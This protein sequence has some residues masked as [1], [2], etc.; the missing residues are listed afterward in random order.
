ME[1]ARH[2]WK[3]CVFYQ[4]YPRSFQDSNGDGMGDLRG[5][6]DRIDYLVELGIGA[7][8]LGPVCK[9]PND[10]MGY[11]I[12]DY[13]DIMEQFGTMADWEE[14][15]DKLHENG[16]RIMVDLVVNHTSDEHPWF[17]AARRAKDDPRH[18]YY[19]WRPGRDGRE[20]NN[21]AS[22]FT[23]SAWEYNEATD[24]YY[25]HLFSKK[26]PDLNW[27]NP[28][29]RREVYDMMTWW[30]DKGADGF[31]MDVINLLCKTPGR[32]PPGRRT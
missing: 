18:D 30:L 29:V 25:L 23:P 5:I 12:S 24:E 20:P 27:H 22:F 9:S 13:Q 2:W 7:I 31:R 4:I 10:D 17:M 3:E 15:R 26:Q 21:W 11:D 1:T 6:I 28:A 19:I 14:L 32:T 8:W 16:I